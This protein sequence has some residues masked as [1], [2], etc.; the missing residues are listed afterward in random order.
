MGAGVA[1]R[2]L[3]V[4]AAVLVVS[5]GFAALRWRLAEL[6]VLEAGERATALEHQ[7]AIARDSLSF[8]LKHPRV[9]DVPRGP[10]EMSESDRE[11]LKRLG[12][13]APEQAVLDDLEKHPELI[14]F[15]GV[16]GGTMF[17]VP[18][19][20]V[21]LTPHWVLGHFEDGHIDGVGLFEFGY[22]KD[23]RFTWKRLAAVLE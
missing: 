6:R 23:G 9:V 21:V 5:L 20:S 22:S 16:E 4:V 10:F 2:W 12:L 1:V 11:Q 13:K 19:Q 18:T 17:F 15:K 8:Q 14:P 3:W 7:V